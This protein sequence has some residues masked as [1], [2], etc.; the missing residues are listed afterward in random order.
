MGT[1]LCAGAHLD[2]LGDDLPLGVG[3]E[4]LVGL[5]KEALVA[6]ARQ[7]AVLGELQDGVVS[8]PLERGPDMVEAFDRILGPQVVEAERVDDR[9]AVVVADTEVAYVADLGMDLEILLGG[10]RL[11]S[12]D[13]F[14]VLVPGLDLD[15]LA[16]EIE[17]VAAFA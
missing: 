5:G 14:G 16:S 13:L 12:I 4:G 1:A 8:A 2:A 3:L 6:C 11:Q 17:G 10:H 7:V 15:A 9:V